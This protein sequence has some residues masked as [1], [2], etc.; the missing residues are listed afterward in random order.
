[1]NTYGK[2]IVFQP[3]DILNELIKNDKHHINYVYI[4]DTLYIR[5]VK[6]K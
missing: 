1:L 5:K 2:P 3:M 4:Q 6:K